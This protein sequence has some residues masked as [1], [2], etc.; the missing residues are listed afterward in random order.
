MLGG[1]NCDRLGD[2]LQAM[3][4]RVFKDKKWMETNK[5]GSGDHCEGH[6]GE[7]G[8]GSG[9]VLMGVL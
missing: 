9:E 8:Q 6:Q 2:T 3:G 4:K 5:A 1:S 7:G